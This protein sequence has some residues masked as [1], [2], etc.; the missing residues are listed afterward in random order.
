MTWLDFKLSKK[1]I[2]EFIDIVNKLR[3][4]SRYKKKVSSLD[5]LNNF[6]ILQ[7]FDQFNFEI[8]PPN[9]KKFFCLEK[10]TQKKRLSPK[11]KINTY[12]LDLIDE[13]YN[14][15][16]QYNIFISYKKKLVEKEIR[17]VKNLKKEHKNYPLYGKTLII[18]DLMNVK[19]YRLTRGS[20]YFNSPIS[21]LD[22][23]NIINLKNA[24]A[25]IIGTAN[26]HELAYGV[27]SKNP[28]F[29]FVRNPKFP[30]LIA[31][32]SSGGSAAAVASKVSSI[33]I[34]TCTGGSIRQPAACCGVMGFKPSFGSI[35]M[36]GVIPLALSLDHVGP[37][38]DSVEDIFNTHV[39]MTKFNETIDKNVTI[40]IIKPKNFF[41]DGLDK[42]FSNAFDNLLSLL[43]K[44]A[45]IKTK[46]IQYIDYAPGAQFITI[47]SEAFSFYK[48]YLNKNN[49]FGEDVSRRLEI[50]KYI[51][52]DDYIK[53][54]SYRSVLR[55]SLDSILSGGEI[56]ITPTIP[57]KPPS[58]SDDH[59]IFKKN[60]KPIAPVLTRFTSPFNLSGSPVIS[61]PFFLGKNDF[62]LSFQLIGAFGSDFHLLSVAKKIEEI[63][64]KH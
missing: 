62:P 51:M 27:T 56:L 6:D 41:Y 24:G 61:M 31:G 44:F 43:S 5:F 47:N 20:K 49:Y 45:I 35:D 63:I 1:K 11:K 26:L 57:I 39:S 50:G 19:G 25:I 13:N 37:L 7:N 60:K 42:D 28:H 59:V 14:S 52:A 17:R 8:Q 40:K 36:K 23:Q 48:K 15:L 53:A 10:G 3:N 22:A 33:A 38:A 21:K 46:K 16:K 2:L 32:G 9:Q 30:E 58:I 29:G 54:Q 55:K 4:K 18:K 34:G 12:L 64:Y